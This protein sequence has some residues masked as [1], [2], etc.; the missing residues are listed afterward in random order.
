MAAEVRQRKPEKGGE[1]Q[2]VKDEDK[3]IVA[4]PVPEEVKDH[5]SDGQKL[6]DRWR[7]TKAWCHKHP[8][9]PLMLV[10]LCIALYAIKYFASPPTTPKV[11][12][13]KSLSL[14]NGQKNA[15]Y[16]LAIMGEVFDVTKGKKH[17]AEDKGYGFF[18]GR[19][20]SRAFITGDFKGDLDDKVTDFD[21]QQCKSLLEWRDFYRKTYPF[22]GRL[23]GPFY[24]AQG[25]PLKAL[26]RVE[27]KAKKAKSHEELRREQEARW[28]SCNVRWTEADGGSVWCDDGQYPRKITTS[29]PDGKPTA[30]CACFKDVGWSDV[31]QIYKG[32]HPEATHC[33][34]LD[35]QPPPG[36]D[37][38]EGT[39]AGLARVKKAQAGATAQQA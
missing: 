22:K 21:E 5:R 16:Y 24:N 11:F 6:R 9:V 14:Y 3:A 4:A 33:K 27:E 19:D 7:A 8:E 25:Q 35:E 10:T 26:Q 18:V 37:S 38:G 1:V 28:P 30:R 34:V 13:K 15:P 2:P 20:A 23:D 29:L 32:C 36:A 31:R 17:Y 12:D 39:E